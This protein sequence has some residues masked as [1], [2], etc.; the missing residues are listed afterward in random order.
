[1]PRIRV[2]GLSIVLLAMAAVGGAVIFVHM[3]DLSAF[4]DQIGEQ[5][6]RFTG[7][8]FEVRGGIDSRLVSLYPAVVLKDVALGNASW[9]KQPHLVTVDRIELR[10]DVLKLL[11]NEIKIKELV[12]I[13]PDI[14]LETDVEGKS[15]VVV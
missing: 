4:R 8:S 11:A 13:D 3:V 2:L 1:M 14:L 10:F 5:V 7:R 6:T 9:G 15:V 12:L